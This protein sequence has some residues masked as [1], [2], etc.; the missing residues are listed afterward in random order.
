MRQ[1]RDGP[2]FAL[3]P[4]ECVGTLGDG[5]RQHFDRDVAA[6][7]RVLGAV[8]LAH[9]AGA[10]RRNDLVRTKMTTGRERH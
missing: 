9:P 8:H 6:E 10:E 4:H 3:E 5:G 1:E 7:A 2:R